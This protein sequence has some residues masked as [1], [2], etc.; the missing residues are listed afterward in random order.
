MWGGLVHL[1]ATR[2]L[3]HISATRWTWWSSAV[4]VLYEFSGVSYWAWQGL[5]LVLIMWGGLVHLSATRWLVHI[6]ATRWTWWSS[7]VIVLYEFSGVSYRAWQGSPLVLIMW[8]GLVHLSATRCLVH[9]S[10]TRGTWWSSAVCV[11]YEFSGVSYRAWQGSPLVL[12]MWG[13]LVHLSAT[14][15]LVHLSATRWTWRFSAVIVLY[16]FSGVSYRAWQGS[17]LVLMMWGWLV[18]LS[19]T[20]CLV[21]ISATRW[22]WWSSA[23]IV[24]YEFSGVSYRAWQGSPLVLIMWEGLVH[25]SATRGTWWSSAVCVLYEFSGV[26][27]RA[28]QGSPLVLIMWEG[29][30]HLSA[31]RGTWW[32]SAVC[33]LYEFSGVSYRAW[34]GLP[35][36]LIMWGGLVHLSATRWLV[37]LSATRWTWWSS[38]VIVLYEFSGVS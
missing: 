23:V 11:L 28:W 35:L 31:T 37:H 3:V 16:E 27:Y 33:V 18:H 1:S 17:P 15:C 26:S 22:T 6:S 8:G 25:L 19:A 36:V 34:Q 21:H 9:L 10:A 20:R 2:C 5:P 32:S 29:L 14:R 13:G 24:L 7:A 38:A 30:V 4:I 12:I